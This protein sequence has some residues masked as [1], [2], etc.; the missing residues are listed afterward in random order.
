MSMPWRCRDVR[1][2]VETFIGG[3]IEQSYGQATKEPPKSAATATARTAQSPRCP[4]L[5]TQT[6]DGSQ[7][8]KLLEQAGAKR[9]TIVHTHTNSKAT[10]RAH[11]DL[12]FRG[13]SASP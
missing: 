4:D 8:S 10:Q 9:G 1:G 3:L 13:G 5:R 2:A 6:G 12:T 7:E 11:T